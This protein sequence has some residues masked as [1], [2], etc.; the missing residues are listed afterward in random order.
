MSEEKKKRLKEYQQNYRE[1]IF[2][3]SLAYF[4]NADVPIK[5]HYKVA[6]AKIFFVRSFINFKK[7]KWCFNNNNN[8]NNNKKP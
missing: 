4:T 1:V 3:N 8:N 6:I 7:I 5:V 2:H